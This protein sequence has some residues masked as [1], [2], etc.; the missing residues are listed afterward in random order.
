MSGWV[1]AGNRGMLGLCGALG[2][3][4][5]GV[6]DDTTIRIVELDL[7]VPPGQPTGTPAPALSSA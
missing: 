3:R 7:R 1:L 4:E 6:P 5:R 2:F